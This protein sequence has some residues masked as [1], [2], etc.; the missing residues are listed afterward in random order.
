MYIAACLE[1]HILQI[2]PGED[3]G[4]TYVSTAEH[5]VYRTWGRNGS[6]H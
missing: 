6:I 4:I 5:I 3:G 2:S 1:D